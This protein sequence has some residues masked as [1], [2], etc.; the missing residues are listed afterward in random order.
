MEQHPSGDD[1]LEL[2]P[3]ERLPSTLESFG[4]AERRDDKIPLYKLVREPSNLNE[5]DWENHHRFAILRD[6][7]TIICIAN[8]SYTWCSER[9]SLCAL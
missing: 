1:L 9:L 7:G 6:N 5:I 4:L 2:I 8:N 3:K